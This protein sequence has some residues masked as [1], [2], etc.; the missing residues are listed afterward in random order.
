MRNYLETILNFITHILF[1]KRIPGE[2]VKQPT[3][4][5]TLPIIQPSEN[6]WMQMF[7]VSSLHGVKQRVFFESR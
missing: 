3:L 7:R 5:T 6:E 2:P 4:K 1:G